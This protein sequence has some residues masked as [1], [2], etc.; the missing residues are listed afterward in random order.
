LRLY[1][2]FDETLQWAGESKNSPVTVTIFA[3]ACTSSDVMKALVLEAYN[4]LVY[5]E[6]AEPEPGPAEVLIRVKACG[7]C[8]SDVHGMDGSTG[9]RIPPLIMGHEAAGIIA[10]VGSKVFDFRP[11]ERVTFDSTIYCG[12]CFY[13]R[14]GEINLCDDR[15]VLGVACDEYRQNGALAEYVVVPQHILYRLPAAVS[16]EHAAMVEPCAIALHAVSRS[17]LVFNATA[18]VV[19]AGMIG[20]LV[21][22]ALRAA[23]CRKLIAIDI[24]PVKLDLAR[25]LGAEVVLNS[26][27]TEPVPEIQKLTDHRGADVVIEAVGI[28][29]S[30]KTALDSVRKGGAVTVIGNLSPTVKL[31]LQRLVAREITL[32]G[33]CASQGDYPV[34]LN[35]MARGTVDVQPLISAVAELAEGA[36]WFQRLYQKEQNLLK[37][38]LVP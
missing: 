10:A 1:I 27:E 28:T 33:S 30:L 7:I 14:R 8:G 4:Q 32:S 9:R 21:I 25:Q 12:S 35:M 36:A 24:D 16:F 20:L 26:Q 31:P 29:S 17:P 11:G 38:I 3:N 2:P 5:R 13:C 37:V 23:G 18:L 22:Q 6:V 15:R 19:G 34:V